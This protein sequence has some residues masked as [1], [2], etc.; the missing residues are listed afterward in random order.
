MLHSR[1]ALLAPVL[2]LFLLPGCGEVVSGGPS[3]NGP[4]AGQRTELMLATQDEIES[5]LPALVV[6]APGTPLG[7]TLPGGCPPAPSNTTDADADGILDD[8][9]ITYTSPPCLVTGLRGGTAAVTGQVRIVDTPANGTT[10]NLTLTDLTWTYTAPGGGLSY[11]VIRD[12]T[13][14]RIG[15][16][17]TIAVS[18]LRTTERQRGD[19][20]ALATLTLDLDWVFIATAAGTIQPDL[21]LPD[22]SLRVTG[23][24]DWD[25]SSEQWSLTVA[26]PT[27]LVYDASC[28]GPQRF[29]AGLM[30][31]T[32]T[33]VGQA[34]T[35]S[36]VWSACGTD[37]ARSWTPSGS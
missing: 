2:F 21:A 22:G 14:A 25:R 18:T 8:A 1:P 36:L 13:I 37:P 33:V 26:T 6:V 9:T 35:L 29:T 15:D 16:A 5:Q 10:F 31:L 34:G 32:G 23:N 11:S 17:D 27:P 19:I 4:S 12:G 30:T 3:G 7:A 20:T 24:L 28:S